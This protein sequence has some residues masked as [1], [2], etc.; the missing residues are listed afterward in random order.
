MSGAFLYVCNKPSVLI[1]H[2]TGLD[3]RGMCN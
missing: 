3:E 2:H 1:N